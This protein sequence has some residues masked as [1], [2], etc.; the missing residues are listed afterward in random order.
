MR[1]EYGSVVGGIV[2]GPAINV[3]M[4]AR[5]GWLHKTL[6]ECR[7]LAGSHARD[8]DS[9]PSG[10]NDSPGTDLA[11]MAPVLG[12]TEGEHNAPN[13]VRIERLAVHILY[14]A[15]TGLVADLVSN[16]RK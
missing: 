1:S 15:I 7:G 8:A 6:A 3:A 12:M 9:H 13:A 2:G 14:G 16:P 5:N 10:W 11:G 4:E